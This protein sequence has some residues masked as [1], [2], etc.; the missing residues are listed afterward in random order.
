[1]MEMGT[2]GTKGT[3]GHTTC[4]GVPYS[5]FIAIVFF[6]AIAIICVIFLFFSKISKKDFEYKVAEINSMAN[7]NSQNTARVQKNLGL[8]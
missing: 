2:K 8:C 7:W 6:L 3:K 5:F 4:S 1:M